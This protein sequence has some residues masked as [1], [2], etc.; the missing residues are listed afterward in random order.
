MRQFV[1]SAPLDES[2]AVSLSGKDYR[3]LVQV[4]RMSEGGRLDVR[5]P[6]GSLGSMLVSEIQRDSKTVLL[7]K[8]ASGPAAREFSAGDSMPALSALPSRFPQIVLFQWVLKGPR[9]DQVVRQATETG[10][11]VIVPVI[12]DRCV[13]SGEL[14][15]AKTE[16]WERIVKEA[17][18]QSGSPIATRVLPPVPSTS[19][20][21]AWAEVS[22]ESVGTSVAIALSEAP[23]ARKSLHEYLE[24]ATG[25]TA[26]AVGPEG[27]MSPREIGLLD[28][29]GF[30]CVHFKTNILRAETAALYGIAAVQSVLLESGN[31]QLKE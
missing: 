1:V 31:W 21:S 10:V 28:L 18:Q 14:G 15:G 11:S 30:A 2:G 12:G 26:I 6:D 17:M 24:T 16:R 22:A 20:G 4:L 8:D 5:F 23:L 9:M 13:A 19:V 7:T 25:M 27:G 29:A 3:Y